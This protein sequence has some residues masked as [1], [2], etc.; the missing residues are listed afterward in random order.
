M[1]L[2]E[3]KNVTKRYDKRG[4]GGVSNLSFSQEEKEVVSIIGHSGAGK[5]TIL[6][7]LLNEIDKDA[8][9]IFVSPDTKIAYISQSEFLDPSKTVFETLF[10][11]IDFIENEEKR[12][13]QVRTTLQTLELTNEIHKKITEISG[14]QRQRV[15]VAKALVKNPTLILMDEPFEHLDQN[16]RQA[17]LKDLFYIFRD[18]GISVLWITHDIKEALIYSDKILVIHFGENKQFSS[19]EKIYHEPKSLFVANLFPETNAYV[20]ELI[21][22]DKDK[23]KIKMLS[24]EITIDKPSDFK[25][26]SLKDVLVII[27]PEDLVIVSKGEGLFK[28]TVQEK[29]FLGHSY[30]LKIKLKEEGEINI[31]ATNEKS[32][33]AGSPIE[34]NL[35]SSKIRV[36]R[37]V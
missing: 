11:E 24:H 31:L 8:G 33:Q 4:I 18:Q 12:T 15:I 10:H 3:F 5:T 9:E 22:E 14:G 37:E 7:L 29:L 36:L 32:Y 21:S 35:R 20:G 23:I 1:S 19:P 16:L 34:L 2:F 25:D 26:S 30:L 28:G 17:L 27:R 13:N 6:K